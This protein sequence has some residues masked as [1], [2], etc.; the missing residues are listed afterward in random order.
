MKK[1]LAIAALT[2]AAGTASAFWNSSNGSYYGDNNGAFYGDGA[3]DAYGDMSFSMSFSGRGNTNMRG[4]GNG[5]GN[6]V[7]NADW[8]RQN[9]FNSRWGNP[10]ANPYY[11]YGPNE[12]W[13]PYGN[14][15]PEA[16]VAE[17]E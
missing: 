15:A 2:L 12:G 4:Y 7:G 16:P 14:Y 13:S 6:G 11:F 5:Y 9:A 3:G 8:T 10:Y 17:A 1:I